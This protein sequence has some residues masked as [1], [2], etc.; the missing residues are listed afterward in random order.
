[1]P[2]SQ[3]PSRLQ[4]LQVSLSLLCNYFYKS[5]SQ[6]LGMDVSRTSRFDIRLKSAKHLSQFERT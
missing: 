4:L 1:M 5:L 2:T 3:A 6:H